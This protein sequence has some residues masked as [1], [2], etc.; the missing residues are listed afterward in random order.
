M[1]WCGTWRV[2]SQMPAQA[3]VALDEY[4]GEWDRLQEAGD[5][6]WGEAG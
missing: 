3:S 5:M 1:R 4:G 6:R 2:T